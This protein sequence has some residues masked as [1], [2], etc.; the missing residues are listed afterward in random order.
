M[1]P[2][3]E[4][5]EI[6]GHP[7]NLGG[8]A[9]G[10]A[11][12]HAAQL[13]VPDAV[14]LS[15][16]VLAP[17]LGEPTEHPADPRA[18]ADLVAALHA[19]FGPAPLAIRS[20]MSLEDTVGRSAA[21]VFT[22]CLAVP[23]EAVAAAI[24][25]V[26]ASA[27][28]P[29]A[30]AYLGAAHANLRANV[31]VQRFVPGTLLVAAGSQ[32]ERAGAP[33]TPPPPLRELIARATAALASPTGAD[34]ELVDDGVALHLV[35]ARPLVPPPP[36]AV[37]AAAPA[38]LLAPLLASGR[39]W[40]LDAAHNPAP[41]SPAQ[42][43]LVE[44]VE[45]AGHGAYQL[46]TVAG[47]LYTTPR[48]G[49]TAPPAPC[50][51]ATLRARTTALL[52]ALAE[53]IVDEPVDVPTAL[54]AY[55]A[56]Y[57]IWADQLGPLAA[58][59]RALLVATHGV[60]PAAT[61]LASRPQSLAALLAR[62]AVA[63]PDDLPP[64]PLA[65]AAASWDVASPTF[66][67]QPDVLRRARALAAPPSTATS[68]DGYAAAVAD[69]LE[70]DDHWFARMQAMVRRA[71]RARAAELRLDPDAAPW[72]ALADLTATP[73]P[74][75]E[76]LHARARA[77]A[78]AH[79]RA[80]A[81][82]MPAVIGDAVGA[83]AATDVWHGLG[84]GDHAPIRGRVLRSGSLGSALLAPRGAV[85]LV[86]AVTPALAIMLGE[87]AALVSDTGGALDHG[88]ALARERGLPALVGCTGAWHG[89]SDGELVE[90]DVVAGTLR[91]V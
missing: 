12:L 6:A 66:G 48:D 81:W 2:W 43:G 26:W 33:I 71:I 76:T 16:A 62:W 77:A 14:V 25:D 1:R 32:V 89:L 18:L 55:Q 60:A 91:R 13:S 65:V 4:L 34:L 37:R 70:L 40:S 22:S 28:G 36:R 64:W 88:A 84:V 9:R 69:L 19:R 27:A 42:A 59:A 5:D 75:T 7:A 15:H 79:D 86:E 83:P 63:P 56:A 8:K 58:A 45:R 52:A 73:P 90:L 24:A 23:P 87:A 47:Y 80:A 50:D 20:S 46:A 85:L 53:V 49:F 54:A 61:L 67:E 57:A 10:L 41:L 39:R 68:S 3:L 29:L 44:L 82:A 38:A 31:I 30:R 74:P 51:A 78:R 11:I 17:L 21:G 72:C 35:Q